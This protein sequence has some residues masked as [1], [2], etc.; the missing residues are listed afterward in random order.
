VLRHELLMGLALG[1]T[2][3]VI[4]FAR[5][6]MTAENV[7]ANITKQRDKFQ[8]VVP[9]GVPRAEEKLAKE[10]EWM[11]GSLAET[12]EYTFTEGVRQVGTVEK[13]ITVML[14]EGKVAGVNDN[15]ANYPNSVVYDFPEECKIRTAPVPRLELGIVI[16][17]A[18]AAICLWGTLIGSM[19]PLLFK[20]L[21]IDPGIASRRRLWM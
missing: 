4:G 7:R 19:L 10:R 17:Q 20:R 8:I 12:K 9:K 14:P 6:L 13:A 5:G 11:L 3:G 16:A 18:V 2:L 15:D 21:G 1:L